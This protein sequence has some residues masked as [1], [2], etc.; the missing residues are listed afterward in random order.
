MTTDYPL[1]RNTAYEHE[2]HPHYAKRH[3][4]YCLDCFNAGVP[5]LAADAA[6][7]KAVKSL[8]E[9]LDTVGNPDVTY[10][11][12]DF[13][14]DAPTLEEAIDALITKGKPCTE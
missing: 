7:W 12:A 2:C 11:H 6:R 4:G 10:W 1:C 9:P 13:M 5:E 14:T 3:D 8:F